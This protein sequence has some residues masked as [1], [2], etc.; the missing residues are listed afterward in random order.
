[1]VSVTGALSP[2]G[3]WSG[4]ACDGMVNTPS[5]GGFPASENK[6]VVRF[7]SKGRSS[8]D[9]NQPVLGVIFKGV[10]DRNERRTLLPKLLPNSVAL[11]ITGQHEVTRWS[12][13]LQTNQHLAARGSTEQTMRDRI[14]RPLRNHSATWPPD[15]NT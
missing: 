6:P 13:I 9:Q 11:G 8:R 10:A 5:M 1:M 15:V 2:G 14:C 12:D 4:R 7:H 3:D